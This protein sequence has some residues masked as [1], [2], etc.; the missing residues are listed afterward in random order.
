MGAATVRLACVCVGEM[1]LYVAVGSDEFSIESVKVGA[2][3]LEEVGAL[4]VF[5]MQAESIIA[6]M[7]MKRVTLLRLSITPPKWNILINPSV[8][9]DRYN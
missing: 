8:D 9:I 1:G 5:L 6:N 2:G 7:I 3:K 4:G